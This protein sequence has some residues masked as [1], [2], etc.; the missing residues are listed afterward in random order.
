MKAVGGEE[1]RQILDGLYWLLHEPA[2]IRSLFI[3]AGD[4]EDDGYD[5]FWRTWLGTNRHTKALTAWFG[6][7]ES[8]AS[9]Y[10]DDAK[11]WMKSASR[12]IKE[13][14]RPL[15]MTAATQWLTKPGYDSGE[16]LSKSEFLVWLLQG[17]FGLVGSMFSASH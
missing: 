3:A 8:V 1:K 15:A 12:S 9:G 4:S 2:G 6:E 11:A 10:G 16:Y 17:Y 14:L 5:V 7:S 13:L